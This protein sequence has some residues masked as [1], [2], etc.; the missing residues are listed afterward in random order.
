MPPECDLSFGK[1]PALTT[2]TSHA[3]SQPSHPQ[4]PGVRLK[5]PPSP[6]RYRRSVR[7]GGLFGDTPLGRAM[8]NQVGMTEAVDYD[9]ERVLAAYAGVPSA[10]QGGAESAPN[11]KP[12]FEPPVLS[13]DGWCEANP[14][15]SFRQPLG[16][17]WG[18][19]SF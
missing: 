12:G 14:T 9:G 7:P 6:L 19:A 2:A 15:V 13:R 11:A 5:P 4:A 10:G 16:G 1:I 17:G 3:N 18:P 8:R